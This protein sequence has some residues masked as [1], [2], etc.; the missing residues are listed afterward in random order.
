[1]RRCLVLLVLVMALPWAG[2]DVVR[3]R[4][5]GELVGKIV[6]SD[7]DSVTIR[8]PTSKMTVPRARI[9]SIE[10]GEAPSDVYARRAAEL[11]DDDVKGHLALADYC[12]EHDLRKQAV[13]ELRHVLSLRPDHASARARLR[14]I[15]DDQAAALVARARR[16]QK[17]GRY[18]QAEEPLTRLL[19]TYPEST[20][21]AEAH[22][23]LARGYAERREYDQALVRWR[24]A[25]NLRPDFAEACEGAAQTCVE[26]T[27]WA[28]ALEFTEQALRI[29]GEDDP[30]AKPLKTR[31]EALGELIELTRTDPEPEQRAARFAREGRL[32]MQLGLA[33]RGTQRLEDAFDAGSRDPELLGYL[34]DYY[35]KRGRVP[36]ALEVLE[37]LTAANPTDRD[38]LARRSRLDRLLFVPKCYETADPEKRRKL[39]FEI[40][41]SG[42]SF[43]YV[44]AALRESAIR[45]PQ[46]TGR[47]SGSFVADRVLTRVPYTC[48]VPN[49]YDPRRP[50]PLILALHRDNATGKEHFYNWESVAREEQYIILCPT[51]PEGGTWSFADLPVP[52][53]AVHHAATVYNIDTDRVYLAGT[54]GGGLLAWAAA[55]R[56]PDHFAGLVVRNARLD[57]VT[58][59]FLPA[60]L[61]LPIYQLVSERAPP[62]IIGSLRESDTT[63]SRW[64]Y[65][66]RH[67]EVP[68]HRHP[69]MPELN[70]KIV[71]WLE[72]KVR[73]PYPRRVRL[74][75]FQYQNAA[76]YWVRIDRFA[77]SVF[78]PQRKV[79]TT[80]PMGIQL[81]EEQV[82]ALYLGRMEREMGSITAVAAPGN[83]IRITTRHVRELT[84]LLSDRLVDLDRPVLIYLNGDLVFRD[85]VDRSLATLFDTAR[86]RR[87]PR[88]CFSAAVPLEV[89]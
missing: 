13:A 62:E 48:Y 24:R 42:A 85:K 51:A 6:E 31:A 57:E 38:L 19:E 28:Q 41:R 26:T 78:D 66:A 7:D 10:R 50:W 27:D 5:G 77:E 72:D 12:A 56:H 29:R 43:A 67:E 32:L 25:L 65:P 15:I 33:D 44:E 87:D 1:M 64:H 36:Q 61:N 45:E 55:L 82:K 88:L 81:T 60:A 16:L 20:H 68:G 70:E 39:L 76:C 17:R 23:L 40:D 84:V 4:N 59:L 71:L 30:A 9:E 89:R 34:V 18:R 83:R 11:A 2:A 79:T 46:K 53:S 86:R 63:L 54:G 74:I 14:T 49:G 75:S 21:A 37:A 58:R 69:A 80:G 35:E 8:T 47:V 3:L 52:L 73:N 22:H